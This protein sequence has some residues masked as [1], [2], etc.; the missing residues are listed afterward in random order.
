MEKA[1]IF[2]DIDGTLL[3]HNKELPASTKSS[4]QALQQAGH[5]V[6]IATGRPPFFF[7][8]LRKELN[9]DSY[10]S[11]NGQ[12]VVYKGEAIFTN[13]LHSASIEQ[14]T[15]FA[16][17][18]NHPLV[19]MNHE[20]MR[21]NISDHPAIEESLNSLKVRPPENDPHFHKERDLFQ[22]LLFCTVGEEKEYVETFDAIRF[23][24]WHPSSVDVIPTNGSK[25]VGIKELI[26]RLGF[27][28]DQVYAFGDERNDL[29]MLSQVGHGVAMGNAPQVVKD[30]ANYVT[31]AVD[32][33]GIKHGLEMVGL[34]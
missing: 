23:V 25:A 17:K 7:E 16:A 34:L 8:D 31:K 12:Y 6:A 32:D 15:E 13:P 20:T 19:Y 27:T 10:V 30:A 11:F 18:R 3:D 21:S 9:I 24:R 5:E 33:D 29:E 14:L 28:I 26:K 22:T 2:F 1:M 4:I